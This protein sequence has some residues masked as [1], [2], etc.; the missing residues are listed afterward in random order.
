MDL[1]RAF[2]IFFFRFISLLYDFSELFL[3][4]LA[5][6]SNIS[7]LEITFLRSKELFLNK[8]LLKLEP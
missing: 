4:S 6:I 3:N 2:L 5:V 1:W 8:L 7:F